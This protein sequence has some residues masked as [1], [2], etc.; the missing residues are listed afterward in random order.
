MKLQSTACLLLVACAWVQRASAQQLVALVEDIRGQ[1]VD[2]EVMDY[3]ATGRTFALGPD[4]TVTVD[5]LN[6]CIRETIHGG[7]V[8]IGVEKSEVESGT[9]E[10]VKLNCDAGKM[11]ATWGQQIDNS[12]YIFRGWRA[13]NERAQNVAR[14]ASPQFTLYGSSPLVELNGNG[15]LIIARLDKKGEQF[16]LYIDQ[17]KLSRR[18][19][20]DFAATN[21]SL[22]P[23]GIYEARWDK[24]L[25]V[26]KI[27][28]AAPSGRSPIIGR[29]LR[30]G[31][32]P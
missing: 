30:L 23:G 6:S 1:V 11:M 3:V 13:T 10:R 28:P 26:F 18:R 25:V 24:R 19:F 5:Y 16:D 14:A 7:V 12:G 20:L 15:R 8:K 4:D 2:L 27:D 29:L 22:T 9:V 21:T 32:A 17:E 31:F